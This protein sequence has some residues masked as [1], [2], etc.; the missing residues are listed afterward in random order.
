[1]SVLDEKIVILYD[2]QEMIAQ[3]GTPLE[4]QTNTSGGGGKG[5]EKHYVFDYAFDKHVA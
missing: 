3:G 4:Y 1:M 2:P 5:R